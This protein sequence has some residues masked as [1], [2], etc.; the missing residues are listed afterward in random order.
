MIV[1]CIWN[2]ILGSSQIKRLTVFLITLQVFSKDLKIINK[3][4]CLK[5][6]AFNLTKEKQIL[7]KG[8]DMLPGLAPTWKEL[9]SRYFHPYKKKLQTKN[10]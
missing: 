4:K 6:L 10:H 3:E 7:K 9:G 2:I 1:L 5:Y 8:H